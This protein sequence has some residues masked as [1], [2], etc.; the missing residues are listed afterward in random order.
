MKTNTKVKTAVSKALKVDSQAISS[1]AY[2]FGKGR[3]SLTKL[4]VKMQNLY[5]GF[6]TSTLRD[7]PNEVKMPLRAGF[8]LSY[9]E[10]IKPE[11]D[12]VPSNTEGAVKT[13][14][15]AEVLE[16]GLDD[17]KKKYAG[18]DIAYIKTLRADLST[19]ISGAVRDMRNALNSGAGTKRA[20]GKNLKFFEWI[21]E[22][23]NE[24]AKKR[25]K[26]AVNKTTDVDTT[27]HQD[28]HTLASKAYIE[29][30]KRV[31]KIK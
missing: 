24:T 21:T 30:Y 5:A 3:I 27:A 13:L 4:A 29:T 15:R 16:L 22:T 7:M 18:V 11:I 31:A 17:L 12:S 1:T 8:I 6:K 25:C 20:R 28:A 9:V 19:Y 2:E 14:P 23:L 10:N 26:N